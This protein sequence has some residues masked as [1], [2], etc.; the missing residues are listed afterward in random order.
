MARQFLFPLVVLLVIA[1]GITASI[2][3]IARKNMVEATRRRLGELRDT[4]QE[5][6]KVESDG[7]N[8]IIEG[9]RIIKELENHEEG[10]AENVQGITQMI[11]SLLVPVEKRQNFLKRV[12]ERRDQLLAEH[13]SEATF[14]VGLPI[15]RRMQETDPGQQDE[16]EL[17][18]LQAIFR[19]P[20]IIGRLEKLEVGM[21]MIRAF[22]QALA[23]QLQQLSQALVEMDEETD[24]GEDV[25]EDDDFNGADD[26][27]TG[28]VG[29]PE[30]GD[31][32]SE[33]EDQEGTA[34]G[35]AAGGIPNE[36]AGNEGPPEQSDNQ[37]ESDVQ[38][39]N[40]AFDAAGGTPNGGDVAG[41]TQD[42]NQENGT[43]SEGE[44]AAGSDV[45]DEEEEEE[46]EEERRV[47]TSLLK[48]L[49][50]KALMRDG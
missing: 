40:G 9:V 14:G 3:Q 47:L 46:E 13:E 6:S 16:A 26:D 22:S 27:V 11:A 25:N 35:D 43:G 8:P 4:F 39:G 20:S 50:K 7:E 18:D 23:E 19:D 41:E 28:N 5:E 36:A 24:N 45:E 37:G 32:Q 1:P 33:S 17:P 30:Q 12:M 48:V 2:S 21:M 38:G 34:A 42:G 31:N 15:L 29:P 10:I 49:T 44:N